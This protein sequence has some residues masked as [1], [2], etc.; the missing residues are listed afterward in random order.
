MI[1]LNS[2]YII[3]NDKIGIGMSYIHLYTY[4]LYTY[5]Y[6][7]PLYRIILFFILYDITLLL[8]CKIKSISYSANINQAP[9]KNLNLLPLLHQKLYLRYIVPTSKRRK[10]LEYSKYELYNYIYLD[11]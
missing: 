11:D 10:S 1:I 8:G 9:I 3:L 2:R 5:T 4:T 7:F 6:T